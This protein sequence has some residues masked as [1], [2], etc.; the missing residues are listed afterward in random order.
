MADV[1]LTTTVASIRAS[2]D[3]A[4]VEE[5]RR[6][7]PIIRAAVRVVVEDRQVWRET[8]RSIAWAEMAKLSPAQWA[9]L[10]EIVIG[11]D[12]YGQTLSP[13]F[14]PSGTFNPRE[15]I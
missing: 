10:R 6:W 12:S 5:L 2:L 1:P 13:P 8:Y 14:D 7:E 4:A 11:D 15:R 9:E 3:F